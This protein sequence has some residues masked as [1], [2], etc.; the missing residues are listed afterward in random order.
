M[1]FSH[2]IV[3]KIKIVAS[4]VS[5]VP[6]YAKNASAPEPAGEL[7]GLPI[8]LAGFKG[9]SKGKEGTGRREEGKRKEGGVEGESGEKGAYR[10]FFPH[11]EPCL[12]RFYAL[13]VTM[14]NR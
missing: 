1:K 12:G 14:Q 4:F 7:T 3:R 5:Y 6:K 2:L 9:P 13:L 10:H 8:H 11:F